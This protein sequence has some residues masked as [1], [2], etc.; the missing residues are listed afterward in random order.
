MRNAEEKELIMTCSIT[1]EYP[2][3]QGNE[4]IVEP[5]E[6]ECLGSQIDAFDVYWR[7][8]DTCRAQRKVG[9]VIRFYVDD[10]VRISYEVEEI[11]IDLNPEEEEQ[12]DSVADMVETFAMLL[13]K[14]P[15]ELWQKV[16]DVMD[17]EQKQLVH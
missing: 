10:I 13:N 2:A 12:L 15:D 1:I 8:I 17:E 6:N 9:A 16:Q 7:A 11:E 3:N 5:L 14:D 4:E